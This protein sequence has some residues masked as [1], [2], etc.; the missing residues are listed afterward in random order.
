MLSKGQPAG[1]VS[2][3][4]DQGNPLVYPGRAIRILLPVRDGAQNVCK[5]HEPRPLE[6]TKLSADVR[7]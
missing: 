1:L 5:I 6:Q 2:F 7:T 3:D 4:M